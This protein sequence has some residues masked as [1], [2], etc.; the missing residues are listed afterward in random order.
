MLVPCAEGDL[1]SI[2]IHAVRSPPFVVIHRAVSMLCIARSPEFCTRFLEERLECPFECRGSRLGF[3]VAKQHLE[4]LVLQVRSLDS[5]FVFSRLFVSDPAS[6]VRCTLDL[7]LFQRVLRPRCC[8]TFRPHVGRGGPQ[9]HH[10]DHCQGGSHRHHQS[11]SQLRS[12]ASHRRIECVHRHADDDGRRL[13]RSVHLAAPS[14][15]RG[16]FDAASVEGSTPERPEKKGGIGGDRKPS[17]D[18]RG[19]FFSRWERVGWTGS[20]RKSERTWTVWKTVVGRIRA[21]GPS[22]G[23]GNGRARRRRSV[24]SERVSSS[25]V[26]ACVDADEAST[27]RGMRDASNPRMD[28]T[29]STEP[30]AFVGNVCT[31]GCTSLGRSIQV[32]RCPRRVGVASIVRG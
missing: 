5:T 9:H 4:I 22:D 17:H 24:A 19:S 28:A 30:N 11:S 31:V 3:R 15:E 18:P 12:R 14:G 26:L 10:Q 25:C 13:C 16:A 27:T 2:Q 1:G 21:D 8:G 29:R 7:H 6:S 23:C 32:E 20:R